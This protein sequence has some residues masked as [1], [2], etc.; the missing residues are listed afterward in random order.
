LNGAIQNYWNEIAQTASPAHNLNTAKSA[1]LFAL[2]NLS[3]ADAVTAFYDGKYA[4]NVWR[5]VTAIRLAADDHNPNT[6]ADS[7]WLPLNT[8]TA[9]DPAYPGA[10]ATISAAGATLVRAFFHQD[11]FNFTAS[12]EVLP[13]VQ[14]RFTRFSEATREATDSRVF[15]GQHFRFDLSSGPRLGRDIAF[16]TLRKALTPILFDDDAE[17]TATTSV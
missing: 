2:L 16:F 15:A 4:Y 14:R 7:N 12:S 17:K 1:R 5:P 11:H 13:G 6:V 8:N 9:P 10:H 3:F